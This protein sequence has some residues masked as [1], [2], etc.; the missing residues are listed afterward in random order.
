MEMRY[1]GAIE[2]DLIKKWEEGMEQTSEMKKNGILRGR[3]IHCEKSFNFESKRV[4]FI[5]T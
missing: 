3:D 2:G 5:Y 4:F 1:H